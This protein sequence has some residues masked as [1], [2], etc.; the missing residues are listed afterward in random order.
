MGSSY[1]S[2]APSILTMH[3]CVHFAL[4]STVC[5]LA[6]YYLGSL[7]TVGMKLALFSLSRH[8][9]YCH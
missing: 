7:M 8:V 9:S 2:T 5:A 3:L 4:N 6:S 1:F